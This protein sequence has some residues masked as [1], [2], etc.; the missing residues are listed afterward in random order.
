MTRR[1]ALLLAISI[2]APA[3]AQ[4]HFSQRAARSVAMDSVADSVVAYFDKRVL[5]LLDSTLQQLREQ[6]VEGGAC[7]QIAERG[8][9]RFEV[10]SVIEPILDEED[11][12]P[13]WRGTRFTCPEGSAPIHWHVITPADTAWLYAEG[14]TAGTAVR[15]RCRLSD[16]DRGPFWSQFPFAAMQCGV[17]IDSITVYRVKARGLTMARRAAIV[18]R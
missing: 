8:T 15:N 9:D 18:T 1:L 5:V 2:A 12:P 3:G 6:L 11:P 17:G 4:R 10:D 7:L 14:D 16:I 13:T